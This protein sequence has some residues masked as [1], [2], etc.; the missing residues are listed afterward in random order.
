MPSE[1]QF[2]FQEN[3]KAVVKFAI[4]FLMKF[5]VPH[6]AGCILKSTIDAILYT[7]HSTV[8]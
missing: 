8:A 3:G 7:E 5:S 2:T 4:Y 6:K 1:I